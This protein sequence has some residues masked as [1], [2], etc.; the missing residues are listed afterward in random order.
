M[1]EH[2]VMFAVSLLMSERIW[3]NAHVVVT[4]SDDAGDVV[5]KWQMEIQCYA[6]YL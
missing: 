1:I 4:Y 5:I 2:E 6:E 3:Y